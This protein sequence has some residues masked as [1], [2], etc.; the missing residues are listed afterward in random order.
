MAANKADIQ[1]EVFSPWADADP[2]PS[3]GIS[4]RVTDLAGKTVGLF[5][6]F[7]VAGYPIQSIVEKKL[8]EKF[9][10][11]TIS[12]FK[13]LET[14]AVADTKDKA[15]FEEWIRRVD[16]VITSVGD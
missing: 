11:I 16:T 4:P 14:V 9:P 13:S 3:R 12:H 10:G 1:Y 2:V 6:N 8:K 15:G 7:K 5:S